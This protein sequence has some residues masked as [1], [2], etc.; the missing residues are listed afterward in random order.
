MYSNTIAISYLLQKEAFTSRTTVEHC[1]RALT[2]KINTISS[3]VKSIEKL[4]RYKLKYKCVNIFQSICVSSI[5]R[6][7]ATLSLDELTSCYEC[8]RYYWNKNNGVMQQIN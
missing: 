3:E 6:G 1:I 4:L 7:G 2:E 5:T 8:R